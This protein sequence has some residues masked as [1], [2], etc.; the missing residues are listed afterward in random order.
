MAAAFEDRPSPSRGCPPVRAWEPGK[1]GEEALLPQS[2]Q[3]P[4]ALFLGPKFS[5]HDPEP[6]DLRR[7]FPGNNLNFLIFQDGSGWKGRDQS[8]VVECPQMNFI[9]P[10]SILD[11]KQPFRKERDSNLLAD[12]NSVQVVDLGVELKDQVYESRVGPPFSF[13]SFPSP[14]NCS[15]WSQPRK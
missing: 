12:E 13:P 3:G 1:G 15:F 10:A 4:Q 7:D 6:D 9:G 14:R 8:S 2:S 11:Q 5:R